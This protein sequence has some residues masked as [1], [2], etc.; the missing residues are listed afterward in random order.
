MTSVSNTT[1]FEY[2]LDFTAEE[3]A[4]DG[5]QWADRPPSIV[6]FDYDGY[7]AAKAAEQSRARARA[8]RALARA[9]AALIAQA[10]AAG[11]T[12]VTLPDGTR[13]EFARSDSQQQNEL[14]QWIA[15][16]ARAPEGH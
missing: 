15:K 7:F 8:S 4:A 2:P 13:L 6:P 16:H 5:W 12:A 14:D 11:A 10:K 3:L 9:Q 1:K